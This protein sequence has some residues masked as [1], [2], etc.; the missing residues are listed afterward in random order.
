MKKIIELTVCTSVLL[1]LLFIFSACSGTSSP[2]ENFNFE[3][4]NGNVI[5]TGYKG[6]ELDIKI[7]DEIE[8]RKV[9]KIGKEAFKEYDM[10]SIIISKNVTTIEQSAFEKCNNLKKIELPNSITEIEGSAFNNCINLEEIILPESLSIIHSATFQKC[11][12]LK[13]VKLPD[14]I[15]LIDNY[16]FADCSNLV[17]I[18]CPKNLQKVGENAFLGTQVANVFSKFNFEIE[19]GKLIKYSG[20]KDDSIIIIPDGVTVIGKSA[21]MGYNNLV[22]VTIPSS[23]TKIEETAFYNCELLTSVYIPESVTEI[24]DH[25][26]GEYTEERNGSFSWDDMYKKVSGFKIKG[27]PGSRAESYAKENGITFVSQ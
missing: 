11:S 1:M 25:A 8:G 18:N 24:G 10:S 26:F 20:K 5:I 6:S 17:E 4:D 3:F 13:S 2:A 14:S 21:F 7:P 19:N 15:T 9:I 22:E 27:K 12:N 16:A 23:V